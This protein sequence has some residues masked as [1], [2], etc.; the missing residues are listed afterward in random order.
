MT[1]AFI[2]VRITKYPPTS[3]SVRV[4]VKSTFFIGLENCLHIDKMLP[5]VLFSVYRKHIPILLMIFS[6][7]WLS[8]RY[9]ETITCDMYLGTNSCI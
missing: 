5:V 2:Q 9:I 8:G 4:L 1:A 3:S 7:F 6:P